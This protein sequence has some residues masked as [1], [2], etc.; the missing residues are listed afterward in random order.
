MGRLSPW[1][2][3]SAS[4]IR[5]GALADLLRWGGAGAM[6]APKQTVPSDER[7]QIQKRRLSFSSPEA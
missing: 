5:R 4:A 1:P 6:P 3:H 7:E 2:F